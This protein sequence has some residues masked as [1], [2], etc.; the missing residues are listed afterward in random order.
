[1]AYGAMDFLLD[2]LDY[3]AGTRPV[4]QGKRRLNL[5]KRETAPSRSRAASVRSAW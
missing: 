1:M 2:A 5:V 3:M 4:E